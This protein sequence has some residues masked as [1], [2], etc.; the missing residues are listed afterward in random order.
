MR[1]STFL[2]HLSPLRRQCPFRTRAH[3]PREW[4][5]A[6]A[7]KGS[8]SEMRSTRC[9]LVLVSSLTVYAYSALYLRRV[10]ETGCT[11]A[12]VRAH[13]TPARTPT[14]SPVHPLE[15][16]HPFAFFTLIRGGPGPYGAYARR[17]EA[18]RPFRR[19]DSED[20]AFHEGNVPEVYAREYKER[21]GCRFVDVGTEFA[22]TPAVDA[23][24]RMW[25]SGLG[26]PPARWT[27][28]DGYKHMCRFFSMR[29]FLYMSKY[30]MVVRLDEDIVVREWEVE[31]FGWMQRNGFVY[32]Y[33][34]IIPE[35]HEETVLTMSAWLARERA[36][37]TDV[38]SIFFT[39][40]F[41]S[42]PRWWLTN[43]R[44]REWL[45]RIDESHH[46]YTHRWGDAPIQSHLV[47]AY[48]PNGSVGQLHIRYDHESTRD[49][50]DSTSG[51]RRE[52]RALATPVADT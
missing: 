24:R 44:V 46:I 10:L 6:R 48:A 1:A 27:Y 9:A 20:I 40:V 49:R 39:N 5:C 52:H 42:D 51:S 31:P 7:Y 35:A 22:H 50:I 47:R 4:E 19:R 41:A 45:L 30:A 43:S 17:C 11:G 2:F 29:W 36:N 37:A 12:I 26:R 38:S 33:S 8:S 23:W 15:P 28:S 13:H 21:Y 34:A 3:A 32:A 18:L 14:P 25:P 16:L